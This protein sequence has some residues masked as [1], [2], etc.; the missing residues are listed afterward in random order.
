MFNIININ[1]TEMVFGLSRI[2]ETLLTGAIM[3]KDTK[4]LSLVPL[5]VSLAGVYAS[6]KKPTLASFGGS[7]NSRPLAAAVSRRTKFLR[8]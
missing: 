1:T 7:H 6:P 8:V 3:F 5:V 4:S 2:S